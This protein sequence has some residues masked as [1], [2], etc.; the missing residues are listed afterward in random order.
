MTNNQLTYWANI[1]RERA[2]KAAEALQAKS[3]AAQYARMATDRAIAAA[4]RANQRYIA[5]LNASTS[6]ENTYTDKYGF[7]AP[8]FSGNSQKYLNMWDSADD[9]FGKLKDSGGIL[10]R[11]VHS[12]SNIA[13][14]LPHSNIGDI[15]APYADSLLPKQGGSYGGTS[16]H[17]S[18]SDNEHGSGGR[19]RFY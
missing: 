17:D 7:L 15:L 12:F 13:Q 19:R 2:D 8:F 9:V 6:R 4:N 16:T 11:F 18:S 10:G 1:E 3:I 5:E 14:A